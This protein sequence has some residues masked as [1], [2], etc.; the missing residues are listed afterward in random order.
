[1]QKLLDVYTAY[2]RGDITLEEAAIAF[3]MAPKA[4]KI[5][6]TKQ[7]PKFPM[8]LSVLDQISVNGLT[9]DE[10]AAALGVTVRSV[11]H[12]A[13][14]WR[15]RRPIPD[16]TINRATSQVKWAVQKKFAVDFIAGRINLDMA[17]EAADVHPRQMRR[18]IARLLDKHLGMVYKDLAKLTLQQLQQIAKTIV[19]QEAM[20]AEAMRIADEI[21]AGRRTRASEALRA[22]VNRRLENPPT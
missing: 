14:R 2:A 12:L 21:A 6:M 7:G 18:I 22:V 11:N 3:D 1:M 4:L 16:D 8:M 10:A 20:T 15:V 5:S 17:A 13:S 19:E 9:R